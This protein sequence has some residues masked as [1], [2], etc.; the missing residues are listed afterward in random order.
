VKVN[1]PPPTPRSLREARGN[2]GHRPLP[3]E[4]VKPTAGAGRP[5][6]LSDAGR[7]EWD[8]LEKELL[9][10][11]LLTTVDRGLFAAYCEAWA[12]FA[13]ATG[14]LAEDG[15]TTTAGN[16]TEIPHPA[17]AIQIRSAELMRKIAADFGFSPADRM[18]LLMP[19]TEDEDEQRK[20]DYFF[21]PRSVPTPR[22]P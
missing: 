15:R 16:G 5:P 3:P 6:E 22:K 1:G 8:R 12:N 20:H 2:P 19:G 21:G 11:G 9:R 17:V 18:R 7:A 14:A 13:W 10:L 4:H